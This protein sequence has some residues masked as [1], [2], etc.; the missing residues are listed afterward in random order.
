MV[1]IRAIVRFIGSMIETED[2][3]AAGAG[4]REKIEEITI[5]VLAV[6]S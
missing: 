1:G 6:F 4:E 2:V 5:L 3:V